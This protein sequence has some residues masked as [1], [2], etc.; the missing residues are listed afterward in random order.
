[1]APPIRVPHDA[2]RRLWQQ[3]PDGVVRE[4]ARCRQRARP[5]GATSLFIRHEQQLQPPAQ[6]DAGGAQGFGREHHRDEAAFHVGAAAPE[7]SVAIDARHELP[8]GRGRHDVVVA[9]KAEGRPRLAEPRA[10]RGARRLH[11]RRDV[12][13][14][15]GESEL[16]Q[17]RFEERDAREIAGGRRILSRNGD[18]RGQ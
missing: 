2:A 8:G 11:G 18:Q 17:R 7:Q 1:M 10:D 3:H 15:E 4:Q 14:L 5:E 6:C 13:A 9:V 12:D 16:R